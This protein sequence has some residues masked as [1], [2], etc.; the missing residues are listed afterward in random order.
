MDISYKLNINRTIRID[1]K[2]AENEKKGLT[3]M[4]SIGL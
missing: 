2:Q 3:N 4:W 1:W